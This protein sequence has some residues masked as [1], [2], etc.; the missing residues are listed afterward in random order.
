MNQTF[1]EAVQS[2]RSVY[3]ISD[4][5]PLPDD[6]IQKLVEQA[7]LHVPSAFNCQS[8]R[9]VVLFGQAHQTLWTITT[10]TLRKRVPAEKFSSTQAKMDSFSAGHGTVLFF[11]DESVTQ[12]LMEQ[13][14]T[15][16]DT[17]PIWAHHS[18]GML[19]FTVWTLLEQAGLGASLQHYNP[20]IDEEVKARWKLPESW[21]L[22][23]QMPFGQ[24]TAQ[25]GEKTFL[26][27]EERLLR[28]EQ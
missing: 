5:S 27:L 11:N 23:A 3:A 19:Q 26:P 16:R 7:V 10:E 14:P 6:E 25:P 17:F 21:K 4:R 9:V 8:G 20:L 13:F 28:F 18:A 1:L 12:G 2:R 15:Y 22:L 24:P